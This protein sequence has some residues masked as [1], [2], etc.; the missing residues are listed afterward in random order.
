MW[1]VATSLGPSA[2]SAALP[3]AEKFLFYGRWIA[4][5]ASIA[6]VVLGALHI[7][8]NLG[9]IVGPI[10]VVIGVFV[11]MLEYPF[12]PI[13]KHLNFFTDYRFRAGLYVVFMIPTFFSVV[14][15][16][17]GLGLFAAAVC[18]GY[19]GFKGSKGEPVTDGTGK[20]KEAEPAAKKESRKS[21]KTSLASKDEIQQV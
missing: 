18:Y 21:K 20:P 1:K 16:V 14:T 10:T 3:G 12:V 8:I 19:A 11:A 13:A 17:G 15:F 9:Y 7:G 5:G 2:A 4:L 6:C